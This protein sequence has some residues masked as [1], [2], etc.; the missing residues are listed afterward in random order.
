MVS[1]TFHW[2]FYRTGGLVTSRNAFW[3]CK[4]SCSISCWVLHCWIGSVC[5]GLT[6][7]M[8]SIS[9]SNKVLY[10]E[11]W[12][13]YGFMSRTNNVHQFFS[14]G[15]QQNSFSVSQVLQAVQLLGHFLQIQLRRFC[16]S[17]LRRPRR[18]DL[19]GQTGI[20]PSS[21]GWPRGGSGRQDWVP[22]V[23]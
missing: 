18:P 9:T 2:P 6:P 7:F 3:C 21:R 19:E 5:D 1:F 14:L 23:E 22:S 10:T 20:G 17:V 15:F 4:F 16:P 11:N 8:D 12:Q 13:N